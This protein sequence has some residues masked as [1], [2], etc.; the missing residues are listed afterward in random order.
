MDAITRSLLHTRSYLILT[1]L[2]LAGLV[3]QVI[4]CYFFVPPGM[5]KY[6][7]TWNFD[8]VEDVVRQADLPVVAI[9]EKSHRVVLLVRDPAL[10]KR[11]SSSLM[12][13]YN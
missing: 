12:T 4:E 11:A 3:C 13:L 7:V 5:Q 9:L 2:V 10:R 1:S 6:S 8:L